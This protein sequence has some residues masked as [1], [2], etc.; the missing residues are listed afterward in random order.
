MGSTMVTTPTHPRFDWRPSS[1][2]REAIVAEMRPLIAELAT[3]EGRRL[4]QLVA[5]RDERSP[6]GATP[7]AARDS[8]HASERATTFPTPNRR[9]RRPTVRAVE[10]ELG[11]DVLVALLNEN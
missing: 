11:Q 7:G 2:E 5:S 8:E 1:A 4:D 10:A 6:T 3:Q 9:R